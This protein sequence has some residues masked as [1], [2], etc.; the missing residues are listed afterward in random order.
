MLNTTDQ[1]FIKKPSP[2]DALH[3]TLWNTE[4][5]WFASKQDDILSMI[6][7]KTIGIIF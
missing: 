7:G 1:A 5:G 4:S 3:G 6:V 2:S